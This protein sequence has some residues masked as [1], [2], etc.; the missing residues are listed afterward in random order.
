[1]IWGR[2]GLVWAQ[3]T[4]GSGRTF[5]QRRMGFYN[6]RTRDSPYGSSVMSL[7]ILEPQLLNCLLALEKWIIAGGENRGILESQ[8]LGN[9]SF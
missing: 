1:M 7:R 4:L 5:D 2:Q 6:L 3:S 8:M 9:A